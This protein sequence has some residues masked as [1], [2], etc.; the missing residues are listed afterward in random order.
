MASTPTGLAK[1]QA[2]QPCPCGTGRPYE[3]C[4]GPLL[5]GQ[6]KAASAEELMRSRFTA[7][8]ANDERYLHQT[9]QPTANLPYVEQ[10]DGLDPV[11]WS[12]LVVHAHELGRTPD[13]AFVDFSA[14]YAVEGGG[15]GVLQEKSEFHRVNGNWLYTRPVRQG[16][17]PLKSTAPKVGRNDPCPCGSGKKYKACCLAKA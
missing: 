16:P 5:A 9:H 17:A 4:C 13:L 10:G 6:R 7:H 8:V 12:R 11:A 14:F 2:G 15:E 3:T 1:P